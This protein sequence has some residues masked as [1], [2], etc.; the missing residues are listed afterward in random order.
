[1]KRLL[2]LPFLCGVIGG[3]TQIQFSDISEQS[4]VGEKGPNYGI[5][6]GDYNND[7]L[8]DIYVTRIGKTQSAI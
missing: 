3:F 5:A 6:F 1:M 2:L 4:G 8:E 7:G